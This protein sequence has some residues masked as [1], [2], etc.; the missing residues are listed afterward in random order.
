LPWSGTPQVKLE[1]EALELPDVD[2]TVVDWM[3]G[4]PAA[5]SGAPLLIIL[6]GLE[7]STTSA[8]ARSLL[9]ATARQGWRAA[10]LHFRDCGDYRNRLPRRYHAGETNDIRYFTERLRTAGHNGPMMAVGFVDLH[11]KLTH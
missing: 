2:V 1:S 6:H 8:Y 7:G 10:V 3:V 5:D 9:D 4:G 11:P